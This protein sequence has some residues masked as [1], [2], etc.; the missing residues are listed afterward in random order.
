MPTPT[1]LPG[2][3]LPARENGLFKKV[4]VRRALSLSRQR[5]RLPHPVTFLAF[6]RTETV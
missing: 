1:P 4:V 3:L 2:Q 5:I 6:L